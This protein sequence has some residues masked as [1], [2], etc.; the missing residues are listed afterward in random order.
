M[1]RGEVRHFQSKG[2]GRQRQGVNRPDFN[3]PGRDLG[4]GQVGVAGYHRRSVAVP[5]FAKS[6]VIGKQ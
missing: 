6:G 1:K 3:G 4:L 5:M 2:I